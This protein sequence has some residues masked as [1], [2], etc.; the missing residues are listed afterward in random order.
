MPA[1]QYDKIMDLK[2]KQRNQ[3]Q[4]EKRDQ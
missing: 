4:R 1:E 2:A 3:A